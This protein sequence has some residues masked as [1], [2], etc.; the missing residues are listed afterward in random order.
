MADNNTTRFDYSLDSRHFHN[1]IS[2]YGDYNQ[3]VTHALENS[4]Y[5]VIHVLENT[6]NET[7]DDLWLH[8]GWEITPEWYLLNWETFDWI[9]SIF[10]VND[11]LI[12]ITYK[13]ID[14]VFWK[15]A[16][17]IA[18]ELRE[19]LRQEELEAKK[20]EELKLKKSNKV[21]KEKSEDE[22][23]PQEPEIIDKT[24]VKN[25]K[26]RS[27]IDLN[28]WTN[29]KKMIDISNYIKDHS[30]DEKDFELNISRFNHL[31]NK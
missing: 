2:R 26:V 22:V 7:S 23:I 4:L 27:I 31:L 5:W 9:D 10:K 12:A 8:S 14:K 24:F 6:W 30:K 3:E 19:R 18:N 15:H 11:G 21:V 28:S 25:V 16:T 17:K 1:V 29:I 20:E 13:N